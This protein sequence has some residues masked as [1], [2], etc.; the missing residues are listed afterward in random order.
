[1]VPI[2]ESTDGKMINEHKV[3]AEFASDY[4]KPEDGVKLWPSEGTNG[5]VAA[6]MTTAKQRL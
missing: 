2:L 3:V 6:C 1:M 4:A 5:D